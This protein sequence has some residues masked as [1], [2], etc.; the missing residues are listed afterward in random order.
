[1][2]AAGFLVVLTVTGFLVVVG[3]V[4]E[5]AGALV[6]IGL[7]VVGFNVVAA[8]GSVGRLR[9][10]L[11]AATGELRTNRATSLFCIDDY[12]LYNH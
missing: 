4:H 9:N 3:H 7:A 1:M 12:S 2:T 8:A 6:V 5:H 11:L 10:E